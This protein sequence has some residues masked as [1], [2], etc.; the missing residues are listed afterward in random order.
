MI[1]LINYLEQKPSVSRNENLFDYDHNYKSDDEDEELVWRYSSKQFNSNREHGGIKNMA[2]KK[3]FTSI[4][5][6]NKL[7]RSIDDARNSA[8]ADIESVV[9]GWYLSLLHSY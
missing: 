4:D 5:R 9:D 3:S 6:Y 7:S 2:K 8:P 1:E